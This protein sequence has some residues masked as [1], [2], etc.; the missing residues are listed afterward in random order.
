MWEGFLK[1]RTASGV[2]APVF[3]R[4]TSYALQYYA[5]AAADAQAL[6][7][8]ALRS[9]LRARIEPSHPSH[10][11]LLVSATTDD[12]VVHFIAAS[13]AAAQSVVSAVRALARAQPA[14]AADRLN[15]KHLNTQVIAFTPASAAAGADAKDEKEDNSEWPSA[16]AAGA[17]TSVQVAVKNLSLRS[18]VPS[19]ATLRVSVSVAGAAAAAVPAYTVSDADGLVPRQ[20]V[21]VAPAAVSVDGAVLFAGAQNNAARNVLVSVV[22]RQHKAEDGEHSAGVVVGEWSNGVSEEMADWSVL[23]HPQAVAGFWQAVH[24]G[25]YQNEAALID[26]A[27]TCVGSIELAV[28][29]S[30]P[31]AAG[32][33]A[34]AAGAKD[35][36]Y[37]AGAVASAAAADEEDI[38]LALSPEETMQ[39]LAERPEHSLSAAEKADAVRLASAGQLFTR[40]SVDAANPKQVQKEDI[41]VFYNAASGVSGSFFWCAPGT[42]VQNYKKR[43]PLTAVPL[44]PLA[45]SSLPLA[46]L[47]PSSVSM[48]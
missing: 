24:S 26:A 34:A 39:L 33:A 38:V 28:T 27:G 3:V 46:S 29:A 45:S 40:Y 15:L 30:K 9:V 10:F 25:S 2:V 11:T 35:E 31:A 7:A 22:V 32:A 43:L 1:S 48:S 8:I 23:P 18:A 14:A 36:K 42:R 4:L 41:F 6:G 16:A 13:A 44:I 37:P 17:G 20:R 19:G 21:A 5:S 12:R 47:P